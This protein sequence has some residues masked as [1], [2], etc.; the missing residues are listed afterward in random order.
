MSQ[1]SVVCI[2]GPSGA[3]KGT[4]ARALARELGWA[5][6]DSGAVYRVLAL[7]VMRRGLAD[8]E[9]AAAATD[10]QL[11]FDLDSNEVWLDGEAVAS[12]I[13]NEDVGGI[14]S[15]LAARPEV[16]EALLAFQRRFAEPEPLVA[17]GRD[18]GTVVFPEAPCKIFL[19]ASAEVRAQRRYLELRDAGKD[20][21]FEQIF[22]EISARDA[23][24]RGRATAPLQAAGDA[25]T[26][27]CT[28]LTVAEVQ[29][30]ARAHL[31]RAGIL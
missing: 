16:R 1:R 8:D 23:R 26:L 24:D 12:E 10:M 2:D 6:L 21:N 3:G 9:A 25:L 11:R 30:A 19:D 14:A 29:K 13:R 15:R 27:D 4:L 17:D 18:M 5:Y 20:A 7:R 31:S 22:R 28:Q